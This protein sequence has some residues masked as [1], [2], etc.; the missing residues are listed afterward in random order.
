MYY[1][2][3]DTHYLLY[4]YDRVRNELVKASDSSNSE[5]NYIQRVLEK[6][7]ELSLSRHENPGYDE[8]SGEGNRG[9]YG[10]VFKNSHLAFDSEQFA[11]FKAVWKWR[12]DTARRFDESTNF[13][14][15]TKDVADIARMNPP[16]AKALHSLLPTGA[17][18]ARPR[19]N[20]IWEQIKEA[21]SR[22]GP[23]LLHFFTSM[24]PEGG[25]RKGL[26]RA[27][28]ETTKLPIPDGEVTVSR[29]TQSQ[30]FGKMPIS[31]RWDGTKYASDQQDDLI[32]FP[33]QRFAQQGTI[34]GNVQYDQAVEESP[35]QAQQSVDM[36]D[37][38]GDAEAPE[39]LDQEF[40]L[41]RGRK[42]KSE[43]VEED[44]SYS[45][46]SESDSDDEMDDDNGVI[47]V[48]DKPNKKAPK[49]KKA[50]KREKK[51]KKERIAK[52]RQAEENERLE[53]RLARKDRQKEKKLKQTQEKENK[54][55]AVPFDYSKATSV[56]HAN[57]ATKDVEEDDG[58]KKKKQKRVFDPYTKTGDE[59]IKG[60]RKAPPVRGER[61]ATFRK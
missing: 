50:L 18:I 19:F 27:V 48:V 49:S 30:L 58:K 41:K 40:T 33:W 15:N 13:V 36:G 60:A 55:E 6:S 38:A 23:S 39:D 61:S 37:T 53:A 47:S 3:S 12:D 32:P 16:D 45:E 25:Q 1:A 42:R 52:Q 56:M 21:K 46:G 20:E 29:L 59:P 11:V 24:A 34:E 2:R 9:W 7:R 44:S 5:S 10:Y 43:A 14:L 35:A 51:E 28:K 4:I 26:P 57:R 31:T 17:P 22:G 54:F 8:N